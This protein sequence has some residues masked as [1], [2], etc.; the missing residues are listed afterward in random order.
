MLVELC[1]SSFLMLCS[2]R[3][4]TRQRLATMPVFLWGNHTLQIT[5]Y[6]E[7]GIVLYIVGTFAIS[8]QFLVLEFLTSRVSRHK[9][10]QTDKVQNFRSEVLSSSLQ[11]DAIWEYQ[12]RVW[13]RL[14]N[15]ILTEKHGYRCA[16]ILNEFGDSAGIEKALLND[17]QVT[18]YQRL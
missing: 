8:T 9:F 18:S 12:M 16:V 4:C 6:L 13:C 11:S 7:N 10:C 17:T 5:A 14:L 15:Y 1:T 2:R 3:D